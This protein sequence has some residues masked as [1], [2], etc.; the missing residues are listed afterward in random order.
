MRNKIPWRTLNGDYQI[1]AIQHSTYVCFTCYLCGGVVAYHSTDP[2]VYPFFDLYPAIGIASNYDHA[3]ATHTTLS[4]AT[5]QS[6]YPAFNL[7]TS[8]EN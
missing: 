8:C 1:V 4:W 5:S 2:A 7:C 6:G 3:E